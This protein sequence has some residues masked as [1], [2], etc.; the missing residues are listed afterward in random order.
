MERGRQ[1]D[2]DGERETE[3]QTAMERGRQ[4]AVERGRQADSDG[5]REA[6]R[7]TAMERGR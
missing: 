5:E 6:E 3:R 7:Q 2:S 1:A 4:T